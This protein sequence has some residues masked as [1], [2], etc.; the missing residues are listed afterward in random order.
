MF[1]VKKKKKINKF[2]LILLI[3]GLDYVNTAFLRMKSKKQTG[4]ELGG[5]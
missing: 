1:L 5:S 2:L 4:C 3:S